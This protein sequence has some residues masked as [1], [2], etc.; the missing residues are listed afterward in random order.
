MCDPVGICRDK[1]NTQEQATILYIVH[2]FRFYSE[3]PLYQ[4]LNGQLTAVSMTQKPGRIYRTQTQPSH[5]ISNH[6]AC[7]IK[8]E[9]TQHNPT[10]ATMMQLPHRKK[11]NAAQCPPLTCAV[12]SSASASPI[13]LMAPRNSSS[14]ITRGGANRMML[15][16]VGFA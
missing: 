8:K 3:F 2:V 5:P 1:Y 14:V 4:S 12:G 6:E 16:C 9:K 7:G 15:P 13:V 10:T 11:K